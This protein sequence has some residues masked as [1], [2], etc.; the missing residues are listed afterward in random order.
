MGDGAQERIHPPFPSGFQ[1]EGREGERYIVDERKNRDR[2]KLRGN[3]NIL[4]PFHAPLVGVYIVQDQDN[5]KRQMGGNYTYLPQS[6]I[7]VHMHTKGQI[8]MCTHSSSHSRITHFMLHITQPS[9][10]LT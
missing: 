3:F 7:F 4:P 2:H 9:R 8:C 5:I 1:R 10:T 6:F